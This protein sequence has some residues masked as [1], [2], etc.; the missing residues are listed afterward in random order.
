VRPEQAFLY[1]T[2]AHEVGKADRVFELEDP[3]Q[4]ADLIARIDSFL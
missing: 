2:A 3:K 1:K 4:V